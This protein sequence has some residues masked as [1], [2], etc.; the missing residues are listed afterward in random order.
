MECLLWR[1]WRKIDRVITAPWC[2]CSHYHPSIQLVIVS[3]CFNWNAYKVQQAVSINGDNIPLWSL[4]ASSR[5]IQYRFLFFLIPETQFFSQIF[6]HQRAE[7]EARNTKMY[8]C[9]G[10][11]PIR[12]NIRHEINL[13]NSFSKKFRKPYFRPNIWPPEGWKW[14]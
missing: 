13:A 6:G 11:H 5:N 4:P 10:T 12:I 7:N 8:R 3:E 1:Y 9:Q 14:G 2:T